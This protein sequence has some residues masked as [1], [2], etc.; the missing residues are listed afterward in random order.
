MTPRREFHYWTDDGKVAALRYYEWKFHFKIQE[1]HGVRVWRDQLTTDRMP[2]LRILRSDPFER[3]WHESIGYDK[4]A[5]ERVFMIAPAGA[6][7][8]EWLQSFKDFPPRQ[9]PG[10]FNLSNVMDAIKK[11]AGDR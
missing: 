3:A 8:G 5:L 11:G 4:W 2:M 10:S 1:S 7:V 6:I 9:K